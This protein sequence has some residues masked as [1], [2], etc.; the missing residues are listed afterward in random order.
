[1]RHLPLILLSAA[2]GGLLTATATLAWVDRHSAT[3]AASVATEPTPTGL[4]HRP[5]RP[6]RP[7]Y[8]L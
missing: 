6:T 1:M 2:L 7:I 4:V 8:N 3:S 5:G